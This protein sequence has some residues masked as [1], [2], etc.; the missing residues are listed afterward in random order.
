MSRDLARRATAAPPETNL[1]A[2]AK[3]ATASYETVVNEL[4]T[5]V[6]TLEAQVLRH[7]TAIEHVSQGVCFFDNEQRLILCNRRYAEIYHL[8]AEQVIPGVPLREIVVH[9]VAVGTCAMPTDDYIQWCTSINSTPGSKVWSAE[10]E[11]GRTIRICHQPMPDGGWVATHED[12]TAL[13]ANRVVAPLAASPNRLGAR[14]PLG[15]GQGRPF[16]GCQQSSRHRQRS[17][18]VQR[19]DRPDG[20]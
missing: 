11:D 20:F 9:R 16:P 15:Q 3:L 6:A 8:A 10:L 1:A 4:R 12:V 14:L 2:L 5:T 19:H 17:S 7:E 18:K 13:E